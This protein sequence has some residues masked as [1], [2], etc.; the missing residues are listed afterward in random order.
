MKVYLVTSLVT[1]IPK[2]YYDLFEELLSRCPE[3]I[4]GI[5]ILKNLD[6][7]TLKQ[8]IGLPYLGAP[9]LCFQLC[10]NILSLRDDPRV[11]LF[12][13]HQKEIYYLD[14]INSEQSLKL[15]ASLQPDLLV[16]VRTRN[17]YRSKALSSARLGCLNIHHGLLPKYRGTLCDLYAL[18]E[19]R[20]AGFSIHRMNKKI[21]DGEI[22][23]TQEVSQA[24]KDYLQ[25]LARTGKV[26]AEALSRLLI[27][28][29][30]LGKIPPGLENKSDQVIITCTPTRKQ[31]KQFHA[32]GMTL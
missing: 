21:D 8:I 29:K 13:K 16:N 26:E 24:E 17:I 20:P 9:K 30:E 10:K 23:H 4:S 25:Y 19:N 7:Q 6:R 1:Y 27:Q 3:Q 22:L 2:N 18:S 32:K 15:L 31:M 14:N 12:K 11:K 28:T 5:I